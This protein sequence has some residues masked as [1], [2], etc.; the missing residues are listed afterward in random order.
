MTA[1][2]GKGRR[3]K[4]LVLGSGALKIGEAGEFDYSGSQALKALREADVD[5]IL[6][7]PN[8]A[9]VQTSE[10]LCTRLY[11]L[12]LDPDVV[13]QV[14]AEEGVDAILLSF[15]GQTALNCGLALAERGVLGKHGVEVLGTPIAAIRDTEDR[16]RFNE[17]L[18]EIGVAYARGETATSLAEAEEVAARIGLPVIVRGA[19]ALGGRGSSIVDRP[20]DLRPA[21]KRIFDAGVPQVLVEEGLAGWK[22]L[23]FEIVRDGADNCICVCT[24][25]NVD[26]LGIHTGDS[27]VVAPCQTLTNTEIQALRSIAFKVIRHL[28]IVGECN[29]QFAVD[30]R[31]FRYRVIE[32]NAR[33]SRSSALASKATGYPL[34]YVAAK[35]CLGA[36]LDGLK[37]A[38]TGTTS[39]FFEPALDYVTCKIPRWDLDKFRG[40]D[41]RIGSEMKSVGEVMSIAR[42]FPE[43]LQKALRMLDIGVAGLEPQA[44]GG[45]DL[46]GALRVA[47]PRRMFAVVKALT[48][49]VTVERVA[50]LSRID[51][52][53]IHQMDAIADVY[54]S[55]GDWRGRLGSLKRLGFSDRQL[56]RVYGVDE[57]AVRAERERLGIRP[58]LL[59]IDTLAAEYPARTNYTYLTYGAASDDVVP[60]LKDTVLILGSGPYRIGSSVEFDWC[61]V[62]AANAARELG[63]ATVVLNCNPETVSTDYD[64]SDLLVFD[65]L[66]VETVVALQSKAQAKGGDLFRIVV[67]MGGQLPNNL[68]LPL[69][70]AGML[71]L[72]TT[73]QNLDRAENR[74]AFSELCDRMHIDQP[75][76]ATATVE[77]EMEQQIEAVGGFPVMVRPSYVLSG[78]AMTVVEGH[79]QLVAVLRRARKVSPE[80]PVV[81]SKFETNAREFEIDAV[82]HAGKVVLL[83]ISEH[84][85]NAGVHSGDATHVLPPQRLYT[86]TIRRARR[87]AEALCEELQITGPF[88]VQ[89]L[90]RDNEVKV[91]ECNLRASR[92]LPFVSKVTG[93][94]FAREALRCM[95]GHPGEVDRRPLEIDHVGVKVPQFSFGRLAGADPF[96]GVEMASTGEVACLGADL[97]EALL[98][99]MGSVGIRAP[100]RGVLLSLGKLPD[101]YR[102]VE[103]ARALARMGLALFATSG[104]AQM[105]R[106]E[107]LDHEV[108]ARSAEE[109]GRGARGVL[110]AGKVDLVIN[111]PR[112]FDAEGRPDGYAIRRAA[113]DLGVALITDVH[114]AR[115]FVRAVVRY[116]DE[117]MP[118]RSWGSYVGTG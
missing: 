30:T 70:A 11:A 41:A 50:E 77:E 20:E 28:G 32:V 111:I 19:F 74:T 13:E 29:I 96:L 63:C 35:L 18:E 117:R 42:S 3:R 17:R 40:V 23:E 16:K 76:W 24:M 92:S 103:E 98:K 4:V 91:I 85:E 52:F 108:V 73:P 116:G 51:P 10:R 31:A 53:F 45:D 21:L 109:P 38:V 80:H 54:R 101:K 65:E 48:E 57:V 75:R 47:S 1:A 14:I 22:E 36:T 102:F 99:A 49:G 68:A 62:S 90:A 5:S 72:G 104:T 95:L 43:A 113:V 100:R 37:N 66:S 56:G 9:T 86:E 64:S 89:F 79:A 118:V 61:C 107:G 67:S 33:L 106:E 8:I 55:P 82:G 44:F 94:D 2:Q 27:I 34:A 15:G 60:P 87:V 112:T 7:N 69:H 97:D 110:E 83:A 59:Q 71:V 58:A 93:R 26:S 84:I 114:V 25:E 78:A 105:L 88:N 39:A 12:P 115:L 6:V 46:E 81:L